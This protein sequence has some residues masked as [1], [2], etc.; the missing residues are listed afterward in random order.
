MH[1]AL[2]ILADHGQPGRRLWR[3]LPKRPVRTVSVVML[4]VDAEDLL[5]V[6]AADDQQ[7]VQALRTDGAHPALR[8]GVRL[9]RSDGVTSTSP[10]SEPNTS[11]K[12]RQN[13]ASWSRG[14]KRTCRHR[15]QWVGHL[16][17]ERAVGGVAP[18][19]QG[20]LQVPGSALCT[21]KNVGPS[22]SAQPL[23]IAH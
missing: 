1:S 17:H 13:F 6:A 2:L 9:G 18:R 14:T 3:L 5:E 19:S 21:A 4:D 7:P 16:Q 20:R 23:G 8:V 22:N 11:S 10:P 15:S 12:L